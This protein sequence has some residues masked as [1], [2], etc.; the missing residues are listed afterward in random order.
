MA[1]GWGNVGLW[2][3]NLYVQCLVFRRWWCISVYIGMKN[4]LMLPP[5]TPHVICSVQLRSEL[6]NCVILMEFYPCKNFCNLLS[7]HLIQLFPLHVPPT[8]TWLCLHKPSTHQNPHFYP[9]FIS[10]SS[11]FLIFIHW[12]VVCVCIYKQVNWS[13]YELSLK[14]VENLVIFSL[15]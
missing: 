9:Y 14:Y 12:C 11:I 6:E 5:A 2:Q 7:S 1:R 15:N 10:L 3:Y 8:H 13:I 4:C